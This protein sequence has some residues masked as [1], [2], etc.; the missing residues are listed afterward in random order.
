MHDLAGIEHAGAPAAGRS[1][2]IVVMRLLRIIGDL[3][4]GQRQ[5][6]SAPALARATARRA[7][8]GRRV[9]AGAQAVLVKT[10]AGPGAGE[11]GVAARPGCRRGGPAPTARAR[12]T[13]DGRK[14]HSPKT[15]S[16]RGSIDRVERDEQRHALVDALQPV[17]PVG[18]ADVARRRA[19]ATSADS[20][21]PTR[22]RGASA[23]A[24]GRDAARRGSGGRR[25]A[26]RIF[27]FELRRHRRASP[28]PGRYA[29]R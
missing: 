21:R 6:G 29:R 27:V 4:G 2:A 12:R 15:S 28:A 25:I 3:L 19:R 1:A 11:P 9:E 5:R 7:E 14:L 23:S 16:S 22:R 13:A 18:D 26:D 24:A 17:H 8:R 20:S 10:V